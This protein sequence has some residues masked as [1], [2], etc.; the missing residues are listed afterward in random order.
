MANS[1]IDIRDYFDTKFESLREYFD[2]KFK[3]MD[4]KF[5]NLKID[6]KAEHI[7]IKDT[8][9]KH[10]NRLSS[11][12][13]CDGKKA[14][15]FLDMIKEAT[16]KWVIPVALLLLVYAFSSGLISRLLGINT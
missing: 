6:N 14:K 3:N 10:E 12:E 9:D 15:T 16:A 5:D 8:I 11:L 1:E 13:N 4:E 7:S 2:E